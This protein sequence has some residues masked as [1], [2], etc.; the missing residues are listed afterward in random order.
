[1]KCDA[2]GHANIDGARFCANCGGLMPIEPEKGQDA[3]IGQLIG[4]RYRVT[5]VLGEGGMGIVYVGEQQMG[6]TVRKVAIKTLHQH[7]SKDPAVL[8]RFHRECG[9]VAQLEHPNTIKFYDFGAT[10]DGTLYIAME[11]VA[12]KSLADVVQLGPMQ[13]DRVIK[14]MRQVCG[15]LDEAHMQGI[16]HRDLK[17]ENIVLAD[18]AGE[19]DFVKVLDFG[20]AARTES[21][22]AQ[23]EA[24]L[25]QQGMVL[26]TPP[27][28]SPEQ[29]TGK[30]LDARS[31]IYS[32]AVMSYE[33]LTGKLPF[34]ADT[35]WQW[36][37][38]HMTAQP[39]PF[40][41]SAPAKHL[42]DGMRKAILRGLSKE[43]EQRPTTAREFFTEL[44]DGGRM[45]VEANPAETA[46]AARTGTAAMEAVPAFAAAAAPAA[47]H[48]GPPPGHPAPTPMAV[49]AA[50]IPHAPPRGGGGGGGGKGLIFGLVGVGAVLLGAILILVVRS[51]KPQN[52]DL[53]PIAINTAPATAATQAPEVIKPLDTPPPDTATPP[54]GTGGG[55][56]APVET[57]KPATPTGTTTKAAGTGTSAA[58][59]KGDPCDACKAA[60]ASGNA[61][62]VNATIGR[63]SDAGKQ[64]ECKTILGRT[65]VGAVKSAAMNGQCDRAKALAAAAEAAGV[66]GAARGLNGSSCK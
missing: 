56:A 66:K 55:S 23:K 12:G 60:A 47:A 28:M 31:D 8:A 26:G 24:K 52:T 20:I 54:A 3:M 32:L 6:S 5:G 27:Y 65:A 38:Q 18:R 22:D 15:A 62:G 14:I 10:A 33:M 58:P 35:P 53:P 41:I 48:Y 64:A 11:F 29:F 7:L 39:I 50:P 25:T 4:G 34:E 59:P 9:T 63:C 51:N 19:K 17:P 46:A 40:E 44:S 13:P 45:T 21:A 61:S 57:T 37:T 30:A 1:M 36:A 2:C 16:I 42:P 43:R 49:A